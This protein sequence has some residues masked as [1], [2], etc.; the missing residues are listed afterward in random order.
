MSGGSEDDAALD[1]AQLGLADALP[2]SADVD[3]RAGLLRARHHH[4]RERAVSLADGVAAEAARAH[5]APLAS[6]DPPLLDVCPE[7]DIRVVALPDSA[8]RI[9]SPSRPPPRADRGRRAAGVDSQRTFGRVR[10]VA[11]ALP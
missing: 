3:L 1:L 10:R 7:P 11:A 6:A 4:R 2:V 9:W 8:G 5:D